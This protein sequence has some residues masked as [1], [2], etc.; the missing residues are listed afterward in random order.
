M[1]LN[2]GCAS[3]E[4]I[5]IL[6]KA[7]CDCLGHGANNNAITILMETSAGETRLGEYR[8]PT[9]NGAGRGVT[10][11]D[12]GT[13]DWLQEKACKAK[14]GSWQSKVLKHFGI[15]L[16]RVAHDDLDYN[17]LLAMLWARMRYLTV[18]AP[19]PVTREGRAKYW[20]QFYN[21]SAGKGTVEHYLKTCAELIGE[22]K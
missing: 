2:Y 13:F 7:V 5:S 6:A 17:P 19:I 21:T 8:D 9:P 14:P 18:T 16:A 12:K 3:R 20:K 15:D 10:Q 1:N 22:S 4:H 11:V